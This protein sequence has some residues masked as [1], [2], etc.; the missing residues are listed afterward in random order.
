MPDLCHEAVEG[1]PKG[2]ASDSSKT[3]GKCNVDRIRESAAKHHRTL[4]AVGLGGF[5]T[6][7]PTEL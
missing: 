1:S 5:E 6:K 4:L 7:P 3:A 2:Q